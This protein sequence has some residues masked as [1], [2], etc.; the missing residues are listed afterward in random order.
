M[1]HYWLLDAYS[2]LFSRVF[3][4]WNI[5]LF[6]EHPLSSGAPRSM[7][8]GTALNKQVENF[9]FVEQSKVYYMLNSDHC[10]EHKSGK[11][12]L[13]YQGGQWGV[14]EKETFM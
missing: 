6:N 11:D 9:V 12:D 10:W 7:N 4:T 2:K 14:T 5:C 3:I 13:K 8:W 1:F